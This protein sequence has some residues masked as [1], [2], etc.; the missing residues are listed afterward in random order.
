[1]KYLPKDSCTKSVWK[2][3]YY[4]DD[5]V[6]NVHVRRLRGKIEDDASAPSYIKTIWGIYPERER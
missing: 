5:N 3:A 2:E 4:G 6:I 1:M